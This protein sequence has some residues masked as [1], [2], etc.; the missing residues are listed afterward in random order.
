MRAQCYKLLS[1][2]RNEI[3]KSDFI[4]EKI[5]QNFNYSR[6]MI[7]ILRKTEHILVSFVVK[8]TV[9]IPTTITRLVNTETTHTAVAIGCVDQHEYSLIKI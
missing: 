7:C 8:Q 6:E 9:N 2:A 5:F 4:D 3:F 1:P